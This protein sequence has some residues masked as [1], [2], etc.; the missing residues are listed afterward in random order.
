VGSVLGPI[1][2]RHISHHD[3]GRAASSNRDDV[4]QGLGFHLLAIP[5]QFYSGRDFYIHAWRA[6]TARTANA[7]G[8]PAVTDNRDDELLQLAAN[9]E[10]SSAH[11]LG[12]AIVRE[13]Q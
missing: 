9:V 5:V 12:E 3:D 13:S 10:R 8:Q 1:F 7:V 4:D 11:P 6:L 2:R